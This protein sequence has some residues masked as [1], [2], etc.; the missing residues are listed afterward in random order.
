MNKTCRQRGS[1]EGRWSRKAKSK[2]QRE[3]VSERVGK[4]KMELK[5]SKEAE[6]A[7]DIDCEKESTDGSLTKETRGHSGL[8]HPPRSLSDCINW[9]CQTECVRSALLH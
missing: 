3:G 9:I 6:L 8:S 5:E 7:V 4:R 1:E 2:T